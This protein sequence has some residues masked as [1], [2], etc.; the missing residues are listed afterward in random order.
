LAWV[1]VHAHLQQ[2][3]R[4]LPRPSAGGTLVGVLAAVGIEDYV[5]ILAL[6][7]AAGIDVAGGVRLHMC[8]C[9]DILEGLL[10]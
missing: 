2:A 5:E 10:H 4:E 1:G 9:K 8:N 7:P 6:E 3:L